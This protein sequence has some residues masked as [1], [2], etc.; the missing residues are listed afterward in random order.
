LE[1][2]PSLES[3]NHRSKYGIFSRF[4]KEALKRVMAIKRKILRLIFFTMP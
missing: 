3:G 4:S 1:V 2:L